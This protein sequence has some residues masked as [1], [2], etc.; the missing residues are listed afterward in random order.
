MPRWGSNDRPS[1][2]NQKPIA[3]AQI[4]NKLIC[5]E[6]SRQ[7]K[8]QNRGEKKKKKKLI[9]RLHKIVS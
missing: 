9:L 3:W 1:L 2:T 4:I 7:A 6:G 5:G 8:V